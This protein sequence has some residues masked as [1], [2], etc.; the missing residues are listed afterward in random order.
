[1]AVSAPHHHPSPAVTTEQDRFEA[2]IEEARQRARR[3]RQS[4]GAVAV[5]IASVAAAIMAIDGSDATSSE[6]SGLNTPAWAAATAPTG[7]LVASMHL[8]HMVLGHGDVWLYLYDDGRLISRERGWVERRLTPDAVARVQDELIST[9]LFDPDRRPP[10]SQGPAAPFDVQVRNGDRLVNLFRAEGQ[11]WTPEF[12]RLAGRLATLQSWLPATAWAQREATP[13]VPAR[14]AICTY[15]H[16]D[17]AD[18][19]AP[20]QPREPADLLPR[21]PASA[22]ALLA[23]ASHVS[24]S[25]TTREIDP[26]AHERFGD[27][28]LC[29]DVTSEQAAR[30]A[31]SLASVDWSPD[32]YRAV[33]HIINDGE[34]PPSTGE[35][36]L[37]VDATPSET[38][39]VGFMPILPHGA[40]GCPCGA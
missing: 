7:E 24:L 19:D 13:Y 28:T 21:L 17:G 23:T 6:P 37:F 40:T 8:W 39:H 1:M 5:G 14:Y 2:L 27:S 29:F 15:V 26:A 18:F 32:E 31:A 3:R 36:V 10:G 34:F 33:G 25:E 30:L 16:G 4:Y 20:P 11:T 22:A 9:G 38:V 35:L 12:D